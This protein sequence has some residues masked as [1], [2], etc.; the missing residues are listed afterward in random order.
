[1]TDAGR[2]GRLPALFISRARAAICGYMVLLAVL[3]DRHLGYYPVA[4]WTLTLVIAGYAALILVLRWRRS[5]RP[6]VTWTLI[7]VDTILIAVLA[8]LTGGGQ[9]PF[10]PILLLVVMAVAIRFG[11]RRA[12]VALG[13]TVPIL[14]T[15][16]VLVPR[17]ARPGDQRARDALWW[18]GHLTAAAVL[19][20]VLSDR[21][22]LAHRRRSQAESD[23]AV[24]RRR[25]DLERDLRRRLEA[26]DEGRRAFLSSLL[27][28]F[29]PSVASVW[30]LARAL[31][32]DE[33][34]L[35][36]GER[37]EMLE[38]V[39]GYA[40]HLDAVLRELAEVLTS[41]SL[42]AE[43]RLHRADI[44]LPR[45]VGE[46]AA[47]SGF[48]V[49]RVVT[50]SQPGDNIVRSDPDKCLRL[51]VKLLE[52]AARNAPPEVVIE[53]DIHRRDDML[54]LCVTPVGAAQEDSLP[55]GHPPNPPG[56]GLW[57]ATRLAEAMGGGLAAEPGAGGQGAVRAWLR[58]F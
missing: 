48:P 3:G 17:P 41:E 49:D 8:G 23:A 11:F 21:L 15:L 37:T 24:E 28:E 46:A 43:H 56:L 51:L 33:E 1:V 58:V 52:E 57:I 7:G 12:A 38:R 55:G 31:R 34:E 54:E 53:V 19:A 29:R 4:A 47:L 20:G 9:S 39:D 32:R 45:L 40:H 27:H 5:D 2:A 30:T 26:L 44:Y 22:D 14:V 10:A 50:R 25:L 13:W 36:A 6:W 16:I 42:D 35:T 18:T